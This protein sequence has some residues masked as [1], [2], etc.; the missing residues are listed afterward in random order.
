MSTDHEG[1]RELMPMADCVTP[2]P[3][4]STHIL[5]LSEGGRRG[6]RVIQVC[7]L[8]DWSSP[9]LLVHQQVYSLNSEK[10]V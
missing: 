5:A 7:S 10:S 6:F 1:G 9:T 3:N 4:E 8:K 2:P